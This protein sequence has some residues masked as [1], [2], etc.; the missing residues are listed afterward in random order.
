[1]KVLLKLIIFLVSL[2]AIAIITSNIWGAATLGTLTPDPNALRDS[3]AN[4]VV[5]VFGATGSVGDGLL[6]A[7]MG[8]PQVETI[9]A[10]TRRMSPRL[11]EGSA[12]GRIQVLMHKDFTLAYPSR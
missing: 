6:K 11:E 5:M 12:S 4:R 8:D 10:V 2:F 7:A 1:M 9:Y 3:T